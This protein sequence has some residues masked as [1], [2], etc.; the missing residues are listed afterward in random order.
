LQPLSRSRGANNE[1]I[2]LHTKEFSFIGFC[3]FSH[4]SSALVQKILLRLNN[5]IP[6][7]GFAELFFIALSDEK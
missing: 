7:P 2:N 5:H 3:F 6:H 1:E 4:P